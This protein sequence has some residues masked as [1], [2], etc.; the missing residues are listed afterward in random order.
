MTI[1]KTKI[2]EV[3]KDLVS[4]AFIF[5]VLFYVSE[6]WIIKNALISGSV[7][8]LLFILSCVF[9]IRNS[10]SHIIVDDKQLKIIEGKK[11]QIFNRDE[12]EF[13]YSVRDYSSC[14]LKV[15][16]KN[17]ESKTIDCTFIGYNQFMC[18]IE[19]LDIVGENAP[20]Y[21]VETKRKGM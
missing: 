2:I 16:S 12:V 19:D 5:V 18:L 6:I 9:R 21:K 3:L 17:G 7:A 11:E 14:Y 15:H 1:Y 20:V 10:K 8:G 4:Y 13:G